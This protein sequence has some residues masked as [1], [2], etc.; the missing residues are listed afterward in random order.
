MYFFLNGLF[1]FFHIAI[2]L[3]AMTG[4]IFPPFRVAHLALMLATLG[5]WFIL[6]H[7]LGSG[8]CPVSDWHWKLKLA[9]GEGR[10]KGTYIHLLLE[11]ITGRELDSDAVDRM[12]VIVTLALTGI[13]LWFNRAAMTGWVDWLGK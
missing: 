3:F 11:R 1:H 10:P 2:I 5:S 12:V 7:W 8:Y 6:G 13:S 4:W 9:L